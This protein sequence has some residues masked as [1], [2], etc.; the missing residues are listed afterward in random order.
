MRRYDVAVH[1]FA[2]MT[3][4][5][6][7]LITPR[8]EDG[9]SLAMKLLGGRYVGYFNRKYERVGTLWTGRFKA[10]PINDERY[11][12]TCIRYIE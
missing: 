1:G 4:H 8:T 9:A 7:L 10:K 5:T 11:W 12:L 3:T 2:L 6:H